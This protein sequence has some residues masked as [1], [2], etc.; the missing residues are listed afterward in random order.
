M[1]DEQVL[2]LLRYYLLD[3]TVTTL[4]QIEQC[5]DLTELKQIQKDSKKFFAEM[6]KELWKK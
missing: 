2:A 4:E 1:T 5:K 6:N 3:H